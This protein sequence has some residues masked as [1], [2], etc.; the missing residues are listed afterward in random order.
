MRGFSILAAAL[1]VAPG[2]A[3]AAPVKWACD[4]PGGH[5]SELSQIQAGP[6]YRVAGTMKWAQSYADR[7][8]APAANIR[9]QSADGTRWIGVNML[10]AA[11]ASRIMFGVRVQNGGEPQDETLGT[12]AINEVV[13]FEVSVSPAGE[14]V[15]SIGGQRRTAQVNIGPGATVSATCSTGEF[16]FGT[17]DLGG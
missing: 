3:T 15:M 1:L 13:P 14:I 9:I 8:Y 5:Y 2:A 11:R 6:V 17:I 12:A 16:E 7:R 10:A 4:T